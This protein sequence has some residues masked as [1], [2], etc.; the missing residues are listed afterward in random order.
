MSNGNIKV[1]I[2]EDEND[3]ANIIRDYL[4]VNQFDLHIAAIF[5]GWIS[6]KIIAK[7]SP[8]ILIVE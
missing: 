8:R 4:S 3:I 7:T 2:V 6:T 5:G 1:L